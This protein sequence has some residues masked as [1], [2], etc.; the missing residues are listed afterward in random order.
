M[1]S[2][3]RPRALT[4]TRSERPRRGAA[5]VVASAGARS[6][7]DAR[8]RGNRSARA[9]RR[10]R[11]GRC[12]LPPLPSTRDR[13][14]PG[15]RGRVRSSRTARRPAGR[16]RRASSSIA[17]SRSSSG[18]RAAGL[19]E[20]ALDLLDRERVREPPVAARQRRVRERI[21]AA[22]ASAGEEG[23]EPAQGRAAAADRAAGEPALRE[24]GEVGV[25]EGDAGAR[26][27]GEPVLPCEIAVVGE[28]AAIGVE[29]ALAQ[30][31][32]AAQAR[33]GRP[34][35]ACSSAA[36][37][38]AVMLPSR[39]RSPRSKPERAATRGAR[40]RGTRAR[41]DAGAARD[42]LGARG[43]DRRD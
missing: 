42:V 2:S 41:S 18:L 7:S 23:V 29:R 33:R 8:A 6:A 17:R 16:W 3:A 22:Y 40:R 15:D 13:C 9:P 32:A 21:R 10:D 24:P 35:P 38:V 19:G 12:S 30:P 20:Q 43:A 31:T 4:N 1:R 28:V 25:D 39:A 26:P 27:V 5:D 36:R 37:A 34:R 11:T 14:G